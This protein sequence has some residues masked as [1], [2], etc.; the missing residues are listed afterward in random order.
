MIASQISPYWP[1]ERQERLLGMRALDPA[2]ID[3]HFARAR[4]LRERD[5]HESSRGQDVRGT[6]G[7][8]RPRQS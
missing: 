5:E 7:S 2:T 1:E 3:R 6:K 8:C 4:Q